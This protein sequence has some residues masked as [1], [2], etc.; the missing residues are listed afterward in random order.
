MTRLQADLA[1][2]LAGLIWGFG[3]VAQKD[4]LN[5]IGPFTFVASR[6]LLSALV[7]LPLA[8]REKGFRG[9]TTGF[10]KNINAGKIMI[11]CA[12][13]AAAVSLQQYGMTATSVTNTA[14]ITGLYVVMVPFIGWFF[15]KQKLSAPVLVACVLSAIGVWL[16]SGGNV[17]DLKI[18]LGHGD[19]FVCHPR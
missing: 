7:V 15:Y 17:N 16:L 3:F 13:F 12:A 9:L 2:C 14:F 4:A 10:S 11:M 8:L 6:F 5:H 18:S 1:L 19:E